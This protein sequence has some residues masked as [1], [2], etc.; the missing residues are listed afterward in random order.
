M[1][2]EKPPVDGLSV[3]QL[4]SVKEI[5]AWT[6]QEFNLMLCFDTKSLSQEGIQ[7]LESLR[8]GSKSVRVKIPDQGYNWEAR[9]IGYE[10]GAK[11]IVFYLSLSNVRA[12]N[13]EKESRHET[14]S[15]PADEGEQIMSQRRITDAVA[16]CNH[17]LKTSENCAAEIDLLL[18]AL[19][20]HP[21]WTDS[22]IMSLQRHLVLDFAHQLCEHG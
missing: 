7:E 6:L 8:A 9:I 18:G 11:I 3:V 2:K 21:D 19:A 17:I 22:D 4:G 1:A 14:C 15:S 10:M 5:A 13:E 20:R 16:K 12:E